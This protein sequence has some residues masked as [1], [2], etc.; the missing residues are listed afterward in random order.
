MM[1]EVSSPERRQ[2]GDATDSALRRWQ[3][4][5]VARY[6]GEGGIDKADT[7]LDDVFEGCIDLLK[8]HHFGNLTSLALID[9]EHSARSL[10]PLLGPRGSLRSTI[11]SLTLIGGLLTARTRQ[12]IFQYLRWLPNAYAWFTGG[13]YGEEEGLRDA[14]VAELAAAADDLDT[15]LT[16]AIHPGADD[17]AFHIINRPPTPFPFAALKHL[18]LDLEPLKGDEL[19]LIFLTNLFPTLVHLELV[20]VLERWIMAPWELLFLRRSVHK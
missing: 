2:K 9:V 3:M 1:E 4:S 17:T 5:L 8:T 7:Y 16:L 18:R 11:Q 19:H 10:D 20:G 15:F 14:T 12:W 13:E 6:D